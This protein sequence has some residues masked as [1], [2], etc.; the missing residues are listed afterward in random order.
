M[1][2]L[3]GIGSFLVVTVILLA[4]LRLLHVGIPIFYPKVLT[5]PFS[6]DRIESV[7]EYT[8]FSPRLPFYRPEALG[9]RPIYITVMRRPHSKVVIF[10]QG[11]HFLKLTEQQGG[12]IQLPGRE[13]RPLAGH[14]EARWRLDGRTLEVVLEMDGLWIEIRTDLSLR[15]TQ[16]IV[17]TLRPYE[18][19]L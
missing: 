3:R 5:G 8:G 14:P 15:D 11:E 13:S 18:E 6:L 7:K 10:W 1:D 2:R 9:E 4:A 17:D 16:R 12:E 19:L